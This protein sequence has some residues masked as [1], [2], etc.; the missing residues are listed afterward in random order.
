MKGTV[1]V[2]LACA[3]GVGTPALAEERGEIG[4]ELGALGYDAL[5]AGDYSTAETQLRARKGVAKNDPAR[6][7]NLGQVLAQ[8]GRVAEAERMFR[9]ASEADEVELILA[10]GSR[11]SSWEAA[12]KA[13]R[14]L[15]ASRVA[16]R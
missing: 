1:F 6:L 11:V 9:R 2:L 14:S 15:R 13:L 16:S 12:D 8:T 3:A 5:I 7:I 4:Y 10:D